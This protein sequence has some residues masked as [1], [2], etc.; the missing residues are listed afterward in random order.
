MK[1]SF[2]QKKPNKTLFFS[3]RC[4]RKKKYCSHLPLNIFYY[5]MYV[6]KTA[7]RLLL[8]IVLAA[9]FLLATSSGDPMLKSSAKDKLA[10][11]CALTPGG[12]QVR[13]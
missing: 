10:F 5:C 3:S 12:R 4:R 13:H 7:F 2:N 6:K 9:D 8:R 11:R 1:L